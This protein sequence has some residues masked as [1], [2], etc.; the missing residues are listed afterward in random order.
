MNSATSC[1]NVWFLLVNESQLWNRAPLVSTAGTVNNTEQGA[2][3]QT[4]FVFT[5]N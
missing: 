2:E 3:I 4:E 5:V 1:A